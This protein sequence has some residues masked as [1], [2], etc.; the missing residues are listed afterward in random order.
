MRAVVLIDETLYDVEDPHFLKGPP[1]RES[2]AEFFVCESLRTLGHEVTVVPATP[3]V[4]A[5]IQNI[6]AARPDFVFN[7]VEEI[8]GHRAYD[9]VFVQ[10]LE[11]LNIPYTGASPETLTLTR[12]KHLSKLMVAEAGVEV[13]KGIIVHDAK[14]ASLRDVPLPAIVKPL[15]LDASEG[16]TA[17][18][19][20]SSADAL[21]RRVS[22]FLREFGGP[23]ICEEY[24]PGR[25]IIVTVSGA[26]ENVTVDSLCEL[27]FPETS[28]IKFA[29]ARAKFDAKY[30][31]SVGIYYRTPTQLDPPI[32]TRVVHAAR[33]AYEALRINAYAKVEFRVD[34]DRVVFIE[35]NANSQMSRRARSTDF[36]SIGYDRFVEKIVKLALA[37]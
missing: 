36:A 29:T 32:E 14:T 30:R 13:P 23:L 20:V 21:Q 8:G 6:Q 31:E 2:E 22:E 10:I 18:S 34:G 17:R 3:D 9:T 16:V 7:L 25:E 4:I 26:N 5:T 35:A 27:A 15:G 12:N 19:Y 24:V 33:T 28:R 1:K 11:V 37:R